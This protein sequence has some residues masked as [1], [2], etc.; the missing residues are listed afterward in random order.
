[1]ATI[2]FKLSENLYLR[3]PQS[4]DLGRSIIE[5][6]IRLIDELGFESFTFKK[7]ADQIGSTEASVYRYF[8]NKHRLLLYLIDWYWTWLDY[9][10][11]FQTHNLPTPREQLQIS[12]RI[13]TE[14]KQVDPQIPYIDEVAL[15]RIVEAEFEKTYLTKEVDSDN[16]DGVFL[17]YKTLCKRIA[18]FISEINVA[19]PFPRTLASTALLAANHQPFY[20]AHLPS[21]TEAKTGIP[22]DELLYQFLE[23][24][25]NKSIA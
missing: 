25:I 16:K 15:H 17:A 18:G 8:E 7:L 22:E 1:M 13:L 12:L 2:V 10:I 20:A 5:A 23:S 3:D 14:K 24:L 6:S 9:R 4:T 11:E 21:L 19:Y